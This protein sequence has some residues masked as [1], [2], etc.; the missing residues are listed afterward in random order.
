MNAWFG[1]QLRREL[2]KLMS[3]SS[4]PTRDRAPSANSQRLSIDSIDRQDRRN[5]KDDSDNMYDG[6]L[7]AGAHL[8]SQENDQ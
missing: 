4:K 6:L 3:N 8:E 2:V 5:P 7:R 1:L